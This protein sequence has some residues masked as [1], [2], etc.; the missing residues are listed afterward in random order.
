MNNKIILF[1]KTR[2][3]STNNLLEKEEGNDNL[4]IDPT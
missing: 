2:S 4:V 3:K 1:Y